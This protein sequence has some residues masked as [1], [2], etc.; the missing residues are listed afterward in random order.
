MRAT[1]TGVPGSISSRPSLRAVHT[2]PLASLTWPVTDE[3]VASTRPSRPRSASTLDGL[4]SDPRCRRRSSAGRRASRRIAA[5]VA[6]G[7]QQVAVVELELAGNGRDGREEATGQAEERVDGGRTG[8]R[9]PVQASQ[10]GGPQGEQKDRGD[11]GGGDDLK[12]QRR[13]E[14]VGAEA[15]ETADRQH[16][17]RQIEGEHLDD[18]EDEHEHEPADPCPL[19][20]GLE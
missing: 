12:P 18:E 19:L 20:D 14:K 3:T 9:S 17:E 13:P 2:S 10:Q 16:Q 1:R 15:G 11:G 6:A 7:G 4:V 5:T 8:V